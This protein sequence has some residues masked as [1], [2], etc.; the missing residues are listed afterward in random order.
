ME[1]TCHE[2][3]S[4]SPKLLLIDHNIIDFDSHLLNKN[5]IDESEKNL[6]AFLNSKL[7]AMEKI[8][9]DDDNFIEG[10]I[11]TKNSNID[12]NIF[13]N[14]E[15]SKSRKSSEAPNKKRTKKSHSRKK[16]ESKSNNKNM[17]INH[18]GRIEKFRMESKDLN[19]IVHMDIDKEIKEKDCNQF[20]SN[21][22]LLNSII[23]EMNDK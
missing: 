4:F 14:I 5:K 3:T 9:L 21:R 8:N 1:P 13:L 12:K 6:I 2:K 22:N 7:E 18:N 23:N 19:D 10:E 16:S 20:F 15:H 11:Q 17:I